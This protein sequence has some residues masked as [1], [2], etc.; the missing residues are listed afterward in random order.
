M[1]VSDLTS[2][3]LTRIRNASKAKR[4]TVEI[5]RSKL[6]EAICGILKDEGFIVNYR[7]IEDKRQGLIKVYLK[8]MSTGAP[9]ITGL[10][11]V[12][13]PGLKIYRGRKELPNVFG[14]I[15]VAIVS[16]SH[17]VMTSKEARKKKTG[18]EVI[19]EAW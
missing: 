3:M 19:C 17:G 9:A 1:A 15:G 4:E 2:D 16:T 6:L 5:K 7:P 10:K 12:S 11:R 8:Y 14:G 13:R 18:G